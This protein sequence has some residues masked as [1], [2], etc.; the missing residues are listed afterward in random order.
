M[1]RVSKTSYLVDDEETVTITATPFEVAPEQIVCGVAGASIEPDPEDPPTFVFDV[2]EQS[3]AVIVA[4]LS[5]DFPPD[6]HG[7]SRFELQVAGSHGGDFSSRTI[8]AADPTH[9]CNI[10][11]TVD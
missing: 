2:A 4:T 11:F 5:A 7:M 3:G 8:F 10:M 1:T 9:D 6:A